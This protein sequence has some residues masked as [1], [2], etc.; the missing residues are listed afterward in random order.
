MDG[1]QGEWGGG[2]NGGAAI[3]W[4]VSRTG[5]RCDYFHDVS[6]QIK[7]I[8]KRFLIVRPLQFAPIFYRPLHASVNM[9]RT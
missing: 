3:N 9:H 6:I 8:V 7:R 4:S 2:L 1:G 5:Q